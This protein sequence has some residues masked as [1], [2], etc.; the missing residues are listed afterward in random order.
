MKGCAVYFE[1]LWDHALALKDLWKMIE[2]AVI[3]LACRTQVARECWHQGMHSVITLYHTLSIWNVVIRWFLLLC[4]R[5]SCYE[6]MC[7]VAQS[8]PGFVES[9]SKRNLSGAGE[10]SHV[11]GIGSRSRSVG[12]LVAKKIK[13]KS[14]LNMSK[15]WSRNHTSKSISFRG[16]S[17]KKTR[18]MKNDSDSCEQQWG[19]SSLQNQWRA[20]GRLQPQSIA[21]AVCQYESVSECSWSTSK[22]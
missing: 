8:Q 2:L 11:D 3:C 12:L 20:N 1:T 14:T 10:V 4:S 9:C 5:E 17:R 22:M 6:K 21:F 15:V 16:Q 19:W 18:L 7:Q 13:G